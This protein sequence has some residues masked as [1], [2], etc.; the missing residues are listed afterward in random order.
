MSQVSSDGRRSR[1][2]GERR[3][4]ILDEKSLIGFADGLDMK[5]ERERDMERNRGERKRRCPEKSSEFS[6]TSNK[7]ACPY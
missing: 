5:Y 6:L 7:K 2:E 1:N 4:G 3:C